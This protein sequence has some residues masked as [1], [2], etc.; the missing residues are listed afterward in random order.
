MFYKASIVFVSTVVMVSI[1]SL[2]PVMNSAATLTL[3]LGCGADASLKLRIVLGDV[4]QVQICCMCGRARARAC[5]VQAP[6][7]RPVSGRIVWG[8]GG[9]EWDPGHNGKVKC[10]S[11]WAFLQLIKDNLLSSPTR[12]YH[13]TS[14]APVG[15]WHRAESGRP[16]SGCT[17]G[18]QELIS[19][20]PH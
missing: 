10:K 2:V 7:H 18:G 1:S 3:F 8:S 5:L 11:C 9:I 6:S 20:G 4:C 19:D 12:W 17:G 16:L 13:V 15:M 14:V